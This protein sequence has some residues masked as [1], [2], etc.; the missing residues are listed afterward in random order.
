MPPSISTFCRTRARAPDRLQTLDVHRQQRPR[1]AARSLPP[2]RR[3][4]QVGFSSAARWPRKTDER[5]GVVFTSP[6]TATLLPAKHQEEV[7]A[8]FL[9][10]NRLIGLSALFSPRCA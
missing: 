5:R 9:N 3:S 10:E 2:R 1:A 7:A 6:P 8:R 4:G